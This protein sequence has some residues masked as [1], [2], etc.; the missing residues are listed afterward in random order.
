MAAFQ[1]SFRGEIFTPGDPGYDGARVVWNGMID[2]RPAVVARCTGVDDVVSAIRFAREQDLV[3]AVRSGGHSVGGFSTCEGGIVID[4]SGMRGVRA[5]AETRVAR[6]NGGALLSELD[7]AA[8][9]LGLA[10]PVGVVGH[11]GVAGLTLGGGMGRLQRRFGLTIDN[12]LSADLVTAEGELVH[13][14]DEA[15]GDLFWG[16]R[17]A[18]AN[19]GVVTSFEFRLHPLDPVVK[20]GIALYPIDRA[21]DA[22]AAFRDL[23]A[24]APDELMPSM[25]V[26]IAS[27]EPPF[28]PGLAGQPVIALGGTHSG[29]PEDAERDLK[30]LRELGPLVDTFAPKP[31]LSVQGMNDEAMAWGKRFYMKGGYLAELTD[32]AMRVA[33]DQIQDAPGHCEITLWGMGGRIARTPDPAM[34]FTG[35][36]APFWLGVEA[37]WDD[38]RDDDAFISWG[39]RAMG[40]LNPFTAAGH[41]VND[42]IET[43]EAIVRSIYGDAKYER[44]VA[45]KRTYDPDNVFRLN[46]N[47]QP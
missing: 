31:Y 27:E 25:N 46:Q 39:R 47:I 9:R 26:L 13:V 40:A 10:C 15:D 32:Q 6:A 28:P 37:L 2:R 41:Y 12:L 11:T 1:D 45:L 8:H 4:L 7:A 33:V 20:Q 3:V 29:S 5:D 24:T 44:L 35:R 16:L 34:A 36:Q 14:S 21:G 43:D 19:F 17:G 23:P 38:P 22:A 18:G 30:P 42:M